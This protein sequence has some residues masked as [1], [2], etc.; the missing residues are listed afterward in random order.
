MH[1]ETI[2]LRFIFRSHKEI[3]AKTADTV[4]HSA[5]R[6]GVSRLAGRVS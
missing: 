1:V 5:G 3:L 4:C 2:V 6:V